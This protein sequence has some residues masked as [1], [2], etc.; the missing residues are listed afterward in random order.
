[1]YCCFP[2]KFWTDKRPPGSSL[3]HTAFTCITFLLVKPFMDFYL[4]AEDK[5]RPLPARSCALNAPLTCYLPIWLVSW[6]IFV[7]I[8][9]I[10]NC[11]M[12][13]SSATMTGLSC[14]SSHSSKSSLVV[15]ET[16]MT[17]SLLCILG[18]TFDARRLWF[19]CVFSK[20]TAAYVSLLWS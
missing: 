16:G 17:D 18:S 19:M 4:H 1:M 2:Q 12:R 20:S 15:L 3:W 7:E 8:P 10:S 6:H 5:V 9:C 14:D 11:G 13:R